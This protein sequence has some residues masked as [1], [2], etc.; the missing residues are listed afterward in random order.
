MT[1]AS[2]KRWVAA[3]MDFVPIEV[4]V[5]DSNTVTN[6]FYTEEQI[7]EMGA[8]K[9]KIPLFHI[10]L[11]LDEETSR[12]KFS[13][14][15]REVVGSIC[16][17]FEQGIKSLQEI[18]QVEQKLMPHL[19]K[20]NQKMYLKAIDLP[21]YR[22]EEPDPKNKSELPDE[23]IWLYDEYDNLRNCITKII[24][25]LEQY[26]ATYAKYEK[27]YL[28]NPTKEME[29]MSDPENWPDVETLKGQII[30]H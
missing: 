1:E 19:F 2:V 26:I 15:A 14:S 11:M 18:V 8:P 25:P 5:K 20:S 10:D 28:F 3:I 21:E 27:E 17:I 23:R 9:E 24:E 12:P 30:F 13:T 7:K 16:M 4:K 29:P 22:P 6:T